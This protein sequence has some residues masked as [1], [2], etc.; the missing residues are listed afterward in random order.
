MP[1]N[2]LWLYPGTG[3][4]KIGNQRETQQDDI[5]MTTSKTLLRSIRSNAHLYFTYCIGKLS[6]F[7]L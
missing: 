4:Q 7:P 6:A 5:L 2:A 3:K 1:N